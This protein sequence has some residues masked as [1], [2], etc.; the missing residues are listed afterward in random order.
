MLNGDTKRTDLTP[1]LGHASDATGRMTVQD[2]RVP[3]LL[4]FHEIEG[5]WP[6]FGFTPDTV[7]LRFRLESTA[8]STTDWLVEVGTARLDKI[9]W[10]VFR[11][12]ALI[13]TAV[14]GNLKETSPTKLAFRHPVLPL[15]LGPGEAV[16]VYLRIRSETSI[17]APLTIWNPEM[18]GKVTGHLEWRSGAYFGYLAAMVAIGLCFAVFN[19]DRIFLVYSLMNACFWMLFFI[20]GGY[21]AWL[22]WPGQRFW[23]HQGLLLS[24]AGC[25]IT[26]LLLLRY[27]FAI[28]R[29]F[30][31]FDRYF[32]WSLMGLTGI[33]L[34]VVVA[35]YRPVMMVELFAAM[36]ICLVVAG[37]SY[38]LFF[39]IYKIHPLYFV[40][41]LGLWIC[42]FLLFLQ[43]FAVTPMWT[44]EEQNMRGVM[45]YGALF[46]LIA[47]AARARKTRRENE[48]I[49]ARELAAVESNKF[50]SLF[51]AN[52]SHEIRA[53]LSSLVGLSQA[54]C[55]QSEKQA[56]PPEFV[57][58][59]N[60]IRVGGQ[61]LNMMLTNLLDVSSA[62]AGR[63][64]VHWKVIKL[65]EWAEQV[66]SLLDPAALNAEVRLEWKREIDA[67]REMETDPIR[68]TQ[69][70]LNL[71]HNAIKFS[72]KGSVVEIGLAEE[73]GKLCLTV[74]DQG[75]G[76]REDEKV[77]IFQ[78]FT[79]GAT[80]AETGPHGAGL[81]LAVVR[82]NAELLGGTVAVENRRCGGACFTVRVPL[83]K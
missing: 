8:R 40:V 76:I 39:R 34:L 20:I 5:A 77:A 21:Y 50:K 1:Y 10:Y 36:L 74:S 31:R 17:S 73:D 64:P 42:G 62:E 70:L 4:G 52:M 49:R 43:P 45:G 68:L 27:L 18:Y 37:C 81:G 41:W 69:I 65:S 11:G 28:P 83:K 12:D 7:W 54:M 19:R 35:P 6:N 25:V 58:F 24:M 33:S 46:F 29:T 47:L 59:L 26:M 72:P 61:Y 80:Q 9:H 82:Q 16:E 79:Q 38:Y 22:E 53:P 56:L 75:P 63:N 2:A 71:I 55:A 67:A 13:Y 15:K 44:T 32:R 3:G 51:L 60:Q 23:T 48:E 14:D 78:S 30:P 57:K 66:R